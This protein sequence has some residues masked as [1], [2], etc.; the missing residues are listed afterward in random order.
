MVI[1]T[2]VNHEGIKCDELER[3]EFIR[4][5]SS[6]LK[7]AKEEHEKIFYQ[8]DKAKHDK[9]W[10]DYRISWEKRARNY[11]KKKWKREKNQDKYVAK[12]MEEFDKM[13]QTFKF[14]GISYFDFD[15]EPWR[16]GIYGEC[17]LSCEV[18]NENA[19]GEC[20]DRIKDNKYF[21]AGQGWILEDHK[22]S[23]PQIKLILPTKFQEQFDQDRKNLEE[24]IRRFYE[25]TTYFGD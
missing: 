22:S 13:D 24:E 20:Y 12:Q 16:N 21:K 5:M 19:L 7:K 2:L 14:R 11:A 1:T 3:K 9:W 17:I 8:L 15:L 18:V 4:L 25:G 10:S 23:R 6:D